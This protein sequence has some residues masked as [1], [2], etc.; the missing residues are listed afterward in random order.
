MASSNGS[1][2]RKLWIDCDAGVDDAQGELPRYFRAAIVCDITEC[3]FDLSLRRLCSSASRAGCSK[4]RDCGHLCRSRQCGQSAVLALIFA[5]SVTQLADLNNW[6]AGYESGVEEYWAGTDSL[7]QVCMDVGPVQI[8]S[9][10][11]LIICN[12]TCCSGLTFLSML[13]QM[14][15]CLHT[16]QTMRTPVKLW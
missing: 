2:I 1:G 12:C 15:L 6:T 10:C 13:E 16:Q 9:I 4:C 7:W 14:S 11:N 8:H 5:S 3:A